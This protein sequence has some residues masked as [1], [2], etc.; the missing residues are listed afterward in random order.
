MDPIEITEKVG[1]VLEEY[2]DKYSLKKVSKGKDGKWYPEWVFLSE[3]KD[4]GAV[5][6]DKK[7]PMGTY[8]GDRETALKALEALWRELKGPDAL[9]NPDVPF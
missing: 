1:V 9:E 7:R 2:K 3:W 4:G 8:L 6:S 5:P